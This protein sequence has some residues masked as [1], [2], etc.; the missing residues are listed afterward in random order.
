MST[1]NKDQ[2]DEKEPISVSDLEWLADAPLYIDT[3]RI[4]ALYDAVLMPLANMS[5]GDGDAPNDEAT[6][7]SRHRPE[8]IEV[9]LT[10]EQ[11]RRFKTSGGIEGSLSLGTLLNGFPGLGDIK[12][13][14]SG[15]AEYE[16]EE[17]S[18]KRIQIVLREVNQP[19]RQLVQLALHYQLYNQDR[20]SFPD[21]PREDW[22]SASGIYFLRFSWYRRG[23]TKR[24]Y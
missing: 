21:P 14:A 17:S 6:L 11:S 22:R 15:G 1:E 12:L 2:D 10:E 5:N 20:I 7:S 13:K 16:G 9:E 4:G 8:R 3:N 23:R 18:S 19:T 24:H